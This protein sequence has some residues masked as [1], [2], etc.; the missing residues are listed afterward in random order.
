MKN[1]N[2]LVRTD[3]FGYKLK[4]IFNKLFIKFKFLT[5]QAEIKEDI[6]K[7]EIES[8]VEELEKE[9]KIKEKN[10]LANINGIIEDRLNENAKTLE[11]Q[12]IRKLAIAVLTNK[13]KIEDVPLKDIEL[14][15]KVIKEDTKKLEIKLEENKKEIIKLRKEINEILKIKA[16]KHKK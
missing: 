9:A 16:K 15:T 5:K 12:R 13:I 3:T 4:S 8:E 7:S 10:T 6:K 14:V 2:E 1:K 11:A